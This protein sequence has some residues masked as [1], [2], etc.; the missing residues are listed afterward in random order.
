ML[1]SLGP[2]CARHPDAP[3]V[4]TCARCGSFL[5][6]ACTEVREE[7]AY[8]EA[9]LEVLRREAP[10]SRAIQGCI[11]LGIAG[12]LGFFVCP[13]LPLLSAAAGVLGLWLPARELRR[14]ERGER[15]SR[16]ARQAKVARGLGWVNAGLM[17]LWGGV[18]L[19]LTL[20]RGRR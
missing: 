11:G 9:C 13:G 16:G 17:V 18:L 19:Y 12:L 2:R 5:C 14:I 3:A 8:C 10:L 15:P 4:A 1:P 20:T 7:A 6:G